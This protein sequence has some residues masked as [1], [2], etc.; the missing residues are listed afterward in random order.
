MSTET[1]SRDVADLPPLTAVV[2]SMPAPALLI[3]D[4]RVFCNRATE[5]L[6]GYRRDEL[7]SLDA[8]FRSLFGSEHE[9]ARSRF[10]ADRAT[11]FPVVRREIITRK[12]GS[13]RLVE[14]AGSICG[15]LMCIL[16]DITDLMDVRLQLQEHAERYRIIKSTSM[17]GFWVIDLHGSVVEVNDAC[18]RILGYSRE[19]LLTM[20]LHDI[21][22]TESVEETQKHIRDIV[23]QG[24]ERFEVRHRRKDGTVID[25]EV[26]TTFQP[27]SRCFHTFIRDISERKQTEEALRKSEERFRLAMEATTDGIWDWNIAADSGYFSPAYYRILGYEPEDFSPSFQVWME[28]LHPEDRE[29]A[30]STNI[31]CVEGRTQG[32]QAEFRM[33][34]KDGSWRWILG[35]GSAVNRD[36]R[37]KAL[38]LI[39]THQDITE[40][41]TAE[42]ALRNREWL[43]RE[44]QRIGC[45]GTYDYDIVHDNWECSAELD[46]I[47][48]I[49]TATPKNLEFWLDL[50]HPEFREKMKDYFA[51][52]LTER[53]WFNMEYKIIRPSDGQER[54]VYG[55]GEF[56][57]DNE[58][59]PVRMIGTIQD[60]TERKQTEETIGKLNRELDRRVMERTGQLEE[61]IREQESF[62]Y[63]VSHDLR[64]PLRHINSY[65]NLVIE[66]YSDQIPVEARYYLERICTASGKMGQLIDDLLELSRV[67]RVELRKGTVNLSKNAASVASM[68]QETEPYRAVDWVIAGDLTAQADRTLIRQ[69]L[70]NLMGNALKYTAKTSRARIEIGS[71]VIDGET[72]FFVRDNGAGFDMAYVN[73]LFRP[74]QRLHGGEFPGT[75]IGLA[76]VQRIIQRHGGRVW[77]EG[78]VNGGATFYFSLPEI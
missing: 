3:E 18:C 41:K 40:R 22:A 10:D 61:A 37:G 60:I 35:R 6:T 66:D 14:V 50:I 19:E 70:L 44:A 76:T 28:L 56:T 74:F 15:K 33:K 75:G 42:E 48:G 55:T 69:V 45:L 43:L 27:A 20:S 30:I 47:F 54:W 1:P 8:W 72:V 64:A 13:R 16:H 25:V 32:F 78:K 26:S 36:R 73:K 39:G 53:T 23:E 63:S 49:H 9:R 77:A 31:D 62:S 58:G 51:S 38:R 46:R 7:S 59:R 52:L 29:R 65:S 24:S 71:A 57:R 17:D 21:D 34:A 68:L 2:E 67:G 12:D 11:G 5:D 4:E